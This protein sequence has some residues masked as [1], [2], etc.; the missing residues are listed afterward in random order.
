MLTLN[1]RTQRYLKTLPLMGA[2]RLASGIF[3]TRPARRDLRQRFTDRRVI[4]AVCEPLFC[5]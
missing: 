5:V 3:N 4:R 1:A 2:T